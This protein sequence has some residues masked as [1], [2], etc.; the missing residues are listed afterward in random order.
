[1]KR[2][3][4]LCVLSFILFYASSYP[5]LAQVPATAK[6]AFMT[7]RNKNRDIYL[8]NPDGSGMERIT[9]HPAMDAGPRW[10]PT[11]EQILFKSDREG[12]KMPLF[13]SDDTEAFSYNEVLRSE[14]YLDDKACKISEPA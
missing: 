9:H 10:S 2:S 6:I 14:N 11:G 5:I 4:I 8:M 3:H 1:M 7:A 12:K 13:R